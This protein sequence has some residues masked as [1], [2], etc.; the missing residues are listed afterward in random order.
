[1]LVLTKEE[2]GGKVKLSVFFDTT[3]ENQTVEVDVW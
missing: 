2:G 3:P 1:M